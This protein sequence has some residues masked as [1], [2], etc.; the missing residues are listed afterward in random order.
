[1]I[2]IRILLFWYVCLCLH[3]VHGEFQRT[4]QLSAIPSLQKEEKLRIV[5]VYF[6]VKSYCEYGLPE[7]IHHTLN[8]TLVSQ[9]P[10]AEVVLV[11]NFQ[12]CYNDSSAMLTQHSSF[13]ELIQHGLH[14]ED[15]VKFMS[16]RSQRFL[17]LSRE[18]FAWDN[19]N[20]LWMTS[21][22]RFFILEDLMVNKGWDEVLHIEADNLLY[23]RAH[24][25]LP[26]LRQHYPLAATPLAAS[27]SLV[28]ASIFWIGGVRHLHTLT[29]FLL[30]LS[31][32]KVDL[33]AAQA[34]AAAAATAASTNNTSL[35]RHVHEAVAVDPALLQRSAKNR[36]SQQSRQHHQ[37]QPPVADTPTAKRVAPRGYPHEQNIYIDYVTWLRP[38]ACCK[39]GGIAADERN[40]G[41]KP[42]AI[43]E[44]SML[45]FFRLYTQL[46]SANYQSLLVNLPVI[47][48]YATYPRRPMRR[49]FVDISGFAPN[50][51]SV[52][53]RLSEG[54]WDPNSWGQYLGGTHRKHG[55]DRGFIDYQHI[56]G[57]AMLLKAC[58]VAMVCDDEIYFRRHNLSHS[59]LLRGLSLTTSSSSGAGDD[60]DYWG[61]SS[62]SS[63]SSSA[64]R[65][66]TAP[67]VTCEGDATAPWRRTP[68]YN[69]H[70][71][72][73]RTDEYLPRPCQCGSSA[74]SSSTTSS[75]TPAVPAQG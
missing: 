57:Q 8:H 46:H 10:R 59:L 37:A 50:G 33:E 3:P 39:V 25:L 67:F 22:L 75:S 60:R 6:M 28:T 43:N 41:L 26:I 52:G 56:A 58:R 51:P 27:E 11:S 14:L 61:L 35:T 18:V 31:E 72:A 53:A 62:A 16:Q 29:D 30:K 17:N 68:L 24:K 45:A 64:E 34:A 15:S 4:K 1:M 32:G 2:L 49:G 23:V 69:L 36:M 73:K 54:I 74:S 21:A 65:C 66:V 71:H 38:F 7:Y 12:D 19:K 63:G 47:P 13:R 70:I 44:M 9:Q 48:M 42:Y 20:E 40:L 55:R 5:F